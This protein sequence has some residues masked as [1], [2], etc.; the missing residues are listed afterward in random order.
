MVRCKQ[1]A[2]VSFKKPA[3][4]MFLKGI[5]MSNVVALMRKAEKLTKKNKLVDAITLYE[6]VLGLEPNNYVA[7]F[8]LG[9][10][11]KKLELYD[12][13]VRMFQATLSLKPDSIEAANNLGIAFHKL[14]RDDEAIEIYQMVL[15]Q[16]PKS[17]ETWLNL[18]LSV[19]ALGDR[20]KAKIFYNEALSIKPKNV[21][22]LANLAE[23]E[24][25]SGNFELAIQFIDRALKLDKK[26]PQ[27]QYNKALS[28]L[29]LGHLE[30]GW[31]LLKHRL[32]IKYHHNLRPWNGQ[33]LKGKRVVI[34][35]EQGVGDQ[36][37]FAGCIQDVI[38]IAESVV[39][40]VEKR[41]VPLFDRTFPQ[42]TVKPYNF[43]KVGGAGNFNYDWDVNSMHFQIP[44]LSLYKHFRPTIG[45]I[46]VDQPKFVANDSLINKFKNKINKDGE[47]IK[48]GFC[49][50]GKVDSKFRE[51]QYPQ[52][53]LWENLFALKKKFPN[54]RFYNL[55]YDECQKE[56]DYYKS[57]F[58]IDLII[59]DELDYRNDIE[60]VA[61]ITSQ[62]DYMVSV[63][64]FPGILAAGLGVK[65]FVIGMEPSWL[66]LGSKELVFMNSV[67]YSTKLALD[68]WGIAI[69][70][71]VL[72]LEKQIGND[73][74]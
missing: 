25:E 64:S 18:G 21:P 14:E 39:I 8:N 51:K 23:L 55:M 26:N 69:E 42:A 74:S 49:W 12:L 34:S 62:M 19:M 31:D 20:E 2:I 43:S 33:N 60:E 45:D 38:D 30:E 36:L 71:L 10:I 41:F 27:L 15:A 58:G 57:K 9:N 67:N 66:L 6:Q 29:A 4:I 73:Y 22:A 11:A 7:T 40:E 61:A 37:M 35:A 3:K 53:D 5:M 56:V 13:A 16:H 72:N 65:T 47:G 46:L 63:V 24:A 54:I 28:I 70:K 59:H 52:S 48:I 68:P 44:M 1:E 17:P 50:R 32:K